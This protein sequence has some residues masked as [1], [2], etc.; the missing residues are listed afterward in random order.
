MKIPP[1]D[2]SV[3]GAGNEEE[4]PSTRGLPGLALRTNLV[5]PPLSS[6]CMFSSLWLG[7]GALALPYLHV[8]LPTCSGT[9]GPPRGC[10][11]KL[12]PTRGGL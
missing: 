8:R 6:S 5:F 7:R 10:Q 12:L 4:L 3:S 11:V 9:N 2:P 1:N